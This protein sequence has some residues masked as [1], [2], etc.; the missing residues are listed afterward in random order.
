[1]TNRSPDDS[2]VKLGKWL[3]ISDFNADA[4][5][6]SRIPASLK[7]FLSTNLPI[8]FYIFIF[9]EYMIRIQVNLELL[10]LSL[11]A[12]FESS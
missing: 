8:F 4:G 12:K 6:G 9:N 7:S 3:F 11:R 10:F 1:M 2:R 5:K